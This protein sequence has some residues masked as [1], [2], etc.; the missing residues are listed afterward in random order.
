MS[1]TTTAPQTVG[2]KVGIIFITEPIQ[3][4]D[5]APIDIMGM[6]EPSYLRALGMPEDFCAKGIEFEYH[7]V[8]ET[9]KGPNQMSA[10]FK[11]AVTVTSQF[12]LLLSDLLQ[13]K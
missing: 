9:G 3:L 11:L 6:M 4:L 1:T 5:V 12:L 8:N 2:I 13:N 10:G 7:Y